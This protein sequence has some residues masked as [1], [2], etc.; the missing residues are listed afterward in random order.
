MYV[1]YV[2][3][4]DRRGGIRE[5]GWEGGRAREGAREA[6]WKEEGRES[7]RG[8]RERRRESWYGVK[9]SSRNTMDP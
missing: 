4:Y 6:G 3:V 1:M 9:S 7:E 8:G 2:F 5:R